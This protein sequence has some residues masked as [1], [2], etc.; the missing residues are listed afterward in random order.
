MSISRWLEN[1][2]DPGVS[3]DGQGR[4]TPNRALWRRILGLQNPKPKPC[5]CDGCTGRRFNRSTSPYVS[6]GLHIWVDKDGVQHWRAKSRIVPF[7]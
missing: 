4:M 2:F 3:V 1:I 7:P 5:T 6:H